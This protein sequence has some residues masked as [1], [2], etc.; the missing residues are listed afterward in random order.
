FKT[1]G[2]SV[3]GRSKGLS[4]LS[5]CGFTSVDIR[6]ILKVEYAVDI[7]Y[8]SNHDAATFLSE[9]HHISWVSNFFLV[10]FK[11]KLAPRGRVFLWPN[12]C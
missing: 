1:S 7:F 5:P 9:K 2:R 3:A 12:G 11:R 8:Q 4:W 6:R 10:Y